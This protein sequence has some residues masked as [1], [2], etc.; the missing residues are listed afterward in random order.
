MSYLSLWSRL[1]L[2]LAVGPLLGVVSPMVRKTS[3]LDELSYTMEVPII[4][5]Y[6]EGWHRGTCVPKNCKI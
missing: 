5:F 2:Q 1:T 3:Q 4:F 6:L